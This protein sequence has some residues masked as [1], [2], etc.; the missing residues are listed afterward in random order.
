VEKWMGHDTM[1]SKFLRDSLEEDLETMKLKNAKGYN[2]CD[3]YAMAAVLDD[4]VA[5][6][7]ETVHATVEL[8]GHLTRGQMVVDWSKVW[9]KNPNVEL[10]LELDMERVQDMLNTIIQ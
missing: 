5:R 3:G 1:K 9:K 7:V 10:I 8:N 4:K 6:C 2:T